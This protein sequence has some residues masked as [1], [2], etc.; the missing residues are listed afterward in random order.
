MLVILQYES[1]GLPEEVIASGCGISGIGPG[2]RPSGKVATQSE[3]GIDQQRGAVFRLSFDIVSGFAPLEI[4]VEETS[5]EGGEVGVMPCK[6]HVEQMDDQVGIG[7]DLC[8]RGDGVLLLFILLRILG[9]RASIFPIRPGADEDEVRGSS[10]D[11]H[12]AIVQ[13]QLAHLSR[14]LF[15]KFG[16]TRGRAIVVCGRLVHSIVRAYPTVPRQY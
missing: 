9:G 1:F 15:F 2:L 5:G 11:A 3:H 12:G 8:P 4:T 10:D 7:G 13:P 6:V 14:Q 16:E